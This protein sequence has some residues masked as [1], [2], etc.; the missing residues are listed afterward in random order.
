MSLAAILE[1]IRAAGQAQIAEIEEQA[2]RQTDEI[3][4]KS[5]QEAEQIYK[6]AYL[7]A[8]EPA[9]KERARIL[10]QARLEALRLTGEARES[11]VDTALEQTRCRLGNTR[12]EPVYPVVLRR[13]LQEALSELNEQ[14]ENHSLSFPHLEADPRDQEL[15]ESILDEM[16]FDIPVRYDFNSWGGVVAKSED[17]RVVVINTLEARLERAIPYLRRYLAAI[18]EDETCR[19]LN[20]ETHAYAP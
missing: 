8:L 18:F 5:R 15:L 17:E 7:S 10:H 19:V 13:L 14:R 3:L 4:V 20:T 2:A 12:G 6:A 11:L 9:A 1:A 16:G